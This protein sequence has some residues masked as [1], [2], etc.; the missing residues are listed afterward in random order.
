MQANIAPL[1]PMNATLE[2][3]RHSVHWRVEPMGNESTFT[4]RVVRVE[5]VTDKTSLW[6]HACKRAQLQAEVTVEGP[7]GTEFSFFTD[8]RSEVTVVA[9]Q[10]AA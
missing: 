9:A 1:F 7:G 5:P 2:V 3:T 8:A 10:K 4:C 6:H